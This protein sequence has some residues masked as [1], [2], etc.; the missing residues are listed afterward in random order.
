VTTASHYSG[1]LFGQDSEYLYRQQ[2]TS[3]LDQTFVRVKKDD[4]ASVEVLHTTP[5]RVT[6]CS[7]LVIV[8]IGWNQLRKAG[9]SVAQRR[10]VR[11]LRLLSS[12]TSTTP[13]GSRL[14]VNPSTYSNNLR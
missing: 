14:T 2:S 5:Y 8:S 3:A 7:W 6:V 10:A 11:I 12:K 1:F 13:Q 4:S 9:Y